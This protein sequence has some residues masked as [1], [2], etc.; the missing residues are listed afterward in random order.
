MA[1]KPINPR[2]IVI[3]NTPT[4]TGNAAATRAPNASTSTARVTGSARRSLRSLSS[5]LIERMS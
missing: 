5:A 2:A 1:S 4:A 3:A